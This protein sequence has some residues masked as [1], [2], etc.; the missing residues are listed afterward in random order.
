MEQRLRAIEDRLLSFETTL[1]G[2][3][4]REDVPTVEAS[5]SRMDARLHRELH[6]HTWKLIGLATALF[7]GALAFSR[8]VH[9]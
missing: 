2:V 5:I 4:M 1:H 6:A 9:P 7:S 8:L 3:A